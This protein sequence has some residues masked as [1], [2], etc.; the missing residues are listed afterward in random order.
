M[1]DSKLIVEIE[2]V[3]RNFQTELVRSF[4]SSPQQIFRFIAEMKKD[5]WLAAHGSKT[6]F[7]EILKSFTETCVHLEKYVFAKSDMQ[8]SKRLQQIQ[9]PREFH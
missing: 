1:I 5:P 8:V 7:R 4:L 9:R 3:G 2:F 6:A